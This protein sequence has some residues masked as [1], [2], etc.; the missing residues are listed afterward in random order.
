MC[1]CVWDVSV[2]VCVY[3]CVI[4]MC[5]CI[6]VCV[7]VFVCLCVCVFVCMS[8]CLCVCMCMW[9]VCL[10]V[11]VCVWCVCVCSCM[12]VFLPVSLSFCLSE[13]SQFDLLSLLWHRNRIYPNRSPMFS[14]HLRWTSKEAV[15][16]RYY[17]IEHT[18]SSYEGLI[19]NQNTVFLSP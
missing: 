3:V 14:V 13:C 10:C 18:L 9:C 4:C 7:C 15:R 1:V 16:S 6:G 19:V 2:C 17:Y 8:V 12:P 11:Y 5:V